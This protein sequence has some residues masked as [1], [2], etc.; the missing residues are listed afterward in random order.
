MSDAIFNF[1]VNGMHLKINMLVYFNIL[2]FW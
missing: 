1:K 2:S